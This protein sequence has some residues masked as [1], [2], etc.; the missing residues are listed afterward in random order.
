MDEVLV[1]FIGTFLVVFLSCLT[2]MNNKDPTLTGITLFITYSFVNYVSFRFSSAHLNPAVSLTYYITKEINVVKFF[3][4][5][6]AQL[7]ASFVAGFMLLFFRSFS[8][9]YLGQPWIGTFVNSS[10]YVV[11]PYQGRIY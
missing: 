5:V 8:K 4:Y 11:N 1:E 2:E 10:E 7:A 9:S 6:G 3:F